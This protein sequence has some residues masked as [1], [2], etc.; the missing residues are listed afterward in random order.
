MAC[1]IRVPRPGLELKPP[2][3]RKNGA[4]T[5]GLPGTSLLVFLESG[6]GR[7]CSRSNER[8]NALL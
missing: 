5:T 4:L 3:L 1:G 7:T 2:V 6:V 8:I